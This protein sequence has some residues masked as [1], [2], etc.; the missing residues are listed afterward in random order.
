MRRTAFPPGPDVAGLSA[1]RRFRRDP[2]G[3]LEE[4]ATHGDVSYLRLPRFP[5][6]LLNHP[7]LVRDVLVGSHRRFRKGPTMQAA[8]RMIGDGLLT[9]EGD[10][11]RRQRRLIQPIFHHGRIAGYAREIVVLASEAADGWADG[12][13]IDAHREMAGLTLAVVARTLFGTDLSNRESRAITDALSG[14]IAQFDRVFSPLLPITQRLPLPAT[15][16]F[17][18]A[19]DTF[20]RLV[21]GLID[22]RRE[23]GATG[24]DLL[25]ML[26]RAQDAGAGMTDTQVRDEVITLFLAG[27]ET[28]SNALTW[29]WYLLS[30]NPAVRDAWQ[31]ELD[32]V[33]GDRPVSVEDLPDLPFTDGVLHEAIRLYPP[34]WA[35]GRT[36]LEPHEAGGYRIPA[37]AT[38]V[39]SPWL[40]HRDDR[41][42]PEPAEFRPGR[43]PAGPDPRHAYVPFGAGPRMCVGEPFAWME[44]AL[45]LVT[46]G[47]RWSLDLAAPDRVQ[48]QPVVTL[49]PRNG[50]PMILRVGGR[51][52]A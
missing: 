22:R 20:D 16:R 10:V 36:A 41:W 49:R 40:L 47:Q 7:D 23:E 26:L 38:A 3:L 29:A 45:L 9:S 6:Y 35:M 14:T 37:G 31:A 43:W 18:A 46:I 24:S 11:H 27:H 19:H 44:A 2:I 39:V 15:R 51:R 32:T 28:T 8:K 48:L 52:A 12:D 42:F 4:A 33:L 17:R 30:Q 50:M 5:V 1:L 13:R 25:S 21:Y 34:S